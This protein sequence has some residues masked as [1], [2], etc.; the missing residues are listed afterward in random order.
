MGWVR[1]FVGLIY[2]WP[3]QLVGRFMINSFRES[4]VDD[5]IDLLDLKETSAW[6]VNYRLL[7]AR[8]RWRRSSLRWRRWPPLRTRWPPRTVWRG[9]G[10][11]WKRRRAVAVT[12]CHAFLPVQDG[13]AGGQAE[14][15]GRDPPHRAHHPAADRAGARQVIHRRGHGMLY[16]DIF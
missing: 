4:L 1:L 15:C 11:C 6:R 16:I 8:P 10:G 5:F 3:D 12:E 13:A 2:R 7:P 9:G 14:L